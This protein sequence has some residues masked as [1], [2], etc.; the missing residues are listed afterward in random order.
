MD[1]SSNTQISV[2]TNQMQNAKIRDISAK[3]IRRSFGKKKAISD[4]ADELSTYYSDRKVILQ[5]YC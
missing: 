3:Q 5:G 1:S 4:V 2:I